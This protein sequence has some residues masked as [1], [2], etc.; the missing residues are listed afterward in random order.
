MIN[1]LRLQHVNTVRAEGRIYQVLID[2][3]PLLHI[4]REYEAQFSQTIN[5]AYTDALNEETLRTSLST[6]GQR[7]LPLG[8]D[9]GVTEC[10]FVTGEI[11][12]FDAYVSWGRWINPYRDQR[13]NKDQGLYWSYKAFPAIVFDVQQYQAAIAEALS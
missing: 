6:I 11:L 1:T 4:F 10:W 9:C 2:D 5:G 7:F 8:C 3:T 12:T 13:D